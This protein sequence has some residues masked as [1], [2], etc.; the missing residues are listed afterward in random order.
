[1]ARVFYESSLY[2]I[3]R[4]QLLTSRRPSLV[5]GFLLTA[6][7]S[8]SSLAA[9]CHGHAEMKGSRRPK[10]IINDL[11][12]GLRRILQLSDDDSTTKLEEGK[13]KKTR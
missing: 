7:F 13:G 9:G 5:A 11:C 1:M 10:R 6:D 12:N 3:I 2:I 4:R 8:L